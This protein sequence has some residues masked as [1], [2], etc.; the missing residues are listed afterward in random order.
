MLTAPTLANLMLDGEWPFAYPPSLASCVRKVFSGEYGYPFIPDH[1]R[2]RRILDVGSNVGASACWFYKHFRATYGWD[3]F[4]DCYEP[5]PPAA[6]L[7][8]INKPPGAKLHRVAV[9]TKPG[10]VKLH[11]GSDW[12]F[13]SLDGGLNPRS[14][15]TV[16]V[17]TLHPGELPEADMLKMDVEGGADD[18]GAFGGENELL[19]EYFKKH[20]GRLKIVSFEWHR[21]RSRRDL[22]G[23]CEA[24]GLR[25]FKSAH[26]CVSLGL[27]VWVRSRAVNGDNRYVMPVPA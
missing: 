1:P 24:D 5:F 8:E 7:C 20:P 18:E 2:V 19:R 12:G 13:S 3:V 25:L 14:G 27:Q 23:M 26:D 22:E 15:E 17:P 16:E 21:E 9:T 11:V 6:D 10:P 4:I